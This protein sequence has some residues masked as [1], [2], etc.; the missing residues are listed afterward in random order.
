MQVR[1]DIWLSF[2]SYM[3][4]TALSPGPNN[5]LALNAAGNY[6]LRRSRNLLLG[7]YVGF[8]LVQLLC[9]A[10]SGLLAAFLPGV[11][12]YMKYLGGGYILWLAWHV[13]V[14]RPMEDDGTV[15]TLS[16]WKGFFLQ[17]V[18]IKIILCGITAFTGY[19]LPYSSSG[20][21]I[22]GFVLLISLIGNGATCLWAVAGAAFSRFL[23]KYW[24]PADLV[25]AAM[26]VCSA[27]HL[28]LES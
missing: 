14:S 22:A 20:W 5:I 13:A 4:V 1:I 8:S 23:K 24:R 12:P 10:F 16:V 11:L 15:R 17:F 21:E 2:L 27:V 3:T 6:G 9:G 28:I 25:M 19:L 18:N 7:I 26:L